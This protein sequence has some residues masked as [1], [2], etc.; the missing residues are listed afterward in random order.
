VDGALRRTAERARL[1]GRVETKTALFPPPVGPHL[2]SLSARLGVSAAVG[3]ER[4][5][6]NSTIA[7]QRMTLRADGRTRMAIGETIVV[8]GISSGVGAGWIN[9]VNLPAAGGLE[10]S[11]NASVLGF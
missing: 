5:L 11:V 1:W 9:G 2:V 8:A 4:A 3:Q 6:G 7:A 10:A